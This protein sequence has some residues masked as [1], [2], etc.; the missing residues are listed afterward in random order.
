MFLDDQKAQNEATGRIQNPSSNQEIDELRARITM[1]LKNRVIGEEAT[2]GEMGMGMMGLPPE[3]QGGY[4][5][6]ESKEQH[7]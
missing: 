7:R 6:Q 3:N 4:G 2:R 1:A 5:L